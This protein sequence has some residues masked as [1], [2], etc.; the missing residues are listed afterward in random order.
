MRRDCS[1]MRSLGDE[2]APIGLSTQ[3]LQLATAAMEREALAGLASTTDECAIPVSQV[4]PERETVWSSGARGFNGVLARIGPRAAP[5]ALA[6]GFSLLVGGTALMVFV[7]NKPSRNSLPQS[8]VPAIALNEQPPHSL[9]TEENS[10]ASVDSSD[11]LLMASGTPDPHE[12]DT[13]H[14][15]GEEASSFA[16]ASTAHD[17]NQREMEIGRAISLAREGRLV[18]HVR[19]RSAKALAQINPSLRDPRASARVPGQAW[20]LSAAVPPPV[21]ALALASI[22]SGAPH[23]GARAREQQPTTLTAAADAPEPP[24]DPAVSSLV[25]WDTLTSVSGI[26]PRRSCRSVVA[27]VRLTPNCMDSLLATLRSS[28]AAVEF[29]EV[30]APIEI[31]LAPNPDSI[32]WWTQPPSNWAARAGVVVLIEAE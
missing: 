4:V 11:S 5:L 24:F 22:E 30:A 21:H 28:G 7:A 17:T 2:A 20:K 14:A 10:L 29:V 1:L 9:N 19:S 26:S 15:P 8:D 16:S 3:V 27:D 31:E 6:A 32:L 25:G 13:S 18:I 12:S 23:H